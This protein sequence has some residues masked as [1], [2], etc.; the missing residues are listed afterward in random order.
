M[1]FS[2]TTWLPGSFFAFNFVFRPQLQKNCEYRQIAANFWLLL[3]AAETLPLDRFT[4]DLFPGVP[5]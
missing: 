1:V 3:G 2:S 5:R 4:R